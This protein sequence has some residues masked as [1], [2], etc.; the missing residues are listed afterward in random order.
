[1]EDRVIDSRGARGGAVIRRRRV[2]ARCG[3]RFTTYEEIV[4]ARLRVI[5]RDGRHEDFDRQKLVD[6]I[7]RACEKRPINAEQ[8]D[9]AVDAICDALE[10][11]YEREVPSEVIGTKVMDRLR[12]MDEVA[13]VR[14]ASVYRRFR[15][16]NEFLNAVQ[17]LIS[18]P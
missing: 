17:G 3:N 15:D 1:V 10:S 12:E 11:D 14:F 7:H 8:I 18:K 2:C 16:V 5:K 13:Y 6:G 4:K 9:A